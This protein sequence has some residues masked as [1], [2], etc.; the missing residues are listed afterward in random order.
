[1][2]WKLLG[3]PIFHNFNMGELK[4][5]FIKYLI[6]CVVFLLIMLAGTFI[7]MRLE[8]SQGIVKEQV[9]SS[10]Q[11]YRDLLLKKY[12]MTADDLDNYV[13]KKINEANIKG[14]ISFVEGLQLT[15][16]IAFTT[17]WGLIVPTTKDSKIFFFF[18][19][20]I[21]IC[22]AGTVLRS[23]GE[24]LILLMHR[25]IGKVERLLFGSSTK[26][27]LSLKCTCLMTLLLMLFITVT[28]TVRHHMGDDWLDAYYVAFQSYTTIGFGDFEERGEKSKPYIVMFYIGWN[29][30]GMAILA[31]LV[32]SILNFE[33]SG[34]NLWN[35]LK[36]S[37]S[38]K[39]NT[40]YN[41]Q[42]ENR[43]YCDEITHS[44]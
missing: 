40:S 43:G 25:L 2:E 13:E 11:Y 18:F 19:S 5:L 6:K 28:A 44:M 15:F 32:G 4:S 41:F 17:G 35:Q 9:V 30:M 1:M 8:S 39:Q 36:R 10:N 31:A 23:V 14:S 34:F 26:N 37:M 22:G 12:D 7:F 33:A 3:Q 38:R 21:S 16:S 24:I 20:I 42:L 29:T 27:Y